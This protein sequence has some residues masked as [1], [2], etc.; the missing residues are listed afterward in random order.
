MKLQQVAQE[1]YIN[2]R[3]RK[4]GWRDRLPSVMAGPTG[5]RETAT[6]SDSS[7]S[8]ECIQDISRLINYDLVIKHCNTVKRITAVRVGSV[9]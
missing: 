9:F 4:I 2:V 1:I 7:G 3:I 8:N 6:A 5:H